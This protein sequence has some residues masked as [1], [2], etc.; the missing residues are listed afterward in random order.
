MNNNRHAHSPSEEIAN[1]ITHGLGFLLSIFGLFENVILLKLM[2]IKI[3]Q[4]K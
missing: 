2:I 3:L 1:T 4:E